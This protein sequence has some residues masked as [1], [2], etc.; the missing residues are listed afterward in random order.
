MYVYST[1]TSTCTCT[2]RC[3]FFLYLKSVPIYVIVH[4]LYKYSSVA[5]GLT[6]PFN[7]PHYSQEPRLTRSRVR[8]AVMSAVATG[9]LSADK[10]VS[11]VSEQQ[12]NLLYNVHVHVIMYDTCMI[13]VYIFVFVIS[14]IYNVY[15][16][17]YILYICLFSFPAC[18]H[19]HYTTTCTN[20]LC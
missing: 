2:C 14:L 18:T 13:H 17:L 15:I 16:V 19:K 5:P 1:Y 12:F 10:I 4:V 9:S 11:S 20:R 7:S 3:S 6:S 8:Q